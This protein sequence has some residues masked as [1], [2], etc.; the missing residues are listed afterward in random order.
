M[1]IFDLA[2]IFE[3]VYGYETDSFNLSVNTLDYKQTAA[4][5][6]PYYAKDLL[7]REYFLPATIIYTTYT[8]SEFGTKA[9]AGKKFSLPYPVISVTG[10]KTIVETQLTERVGT[11][12]ELIN[13]Q[14]YEI[15]IK[16][17]LINNEDDFPEDDMATLIEIFES[18]YPVQLQNA[19]TDIFLVNPDRKGSDNAVI[20]DLSFPE[21]RGI[22]NVKP[23]QLT[24]VSDAIFSLDEIK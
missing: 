16:G 23:Y 8:T 19:L 17:F 13:V 21:V 18:Q 4:K 12:K 14:D 9:P 5:G 1:N 22:K 10:R 24:L 7:G 15:I 2:G 20:K 3:Q 11:V 6:S